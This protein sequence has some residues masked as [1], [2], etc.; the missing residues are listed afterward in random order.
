M[1]LNPRYW[2]H[3]LNKRLPILMP[4]TRQRRYWDFFVLTLVVWTALVVPFEVGFG[5]I[6][7]PGGYQ[8]ERLIDACF[9][10]D[11]CLN[12]RTA[13]IDHSANM[14]RDGAKIAGHYIR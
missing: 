8:I 4:E 2:I 9:W 5:S 10:V 3:I 7:F 13:Y 6:N 11:V 12:F 14:V 1:K